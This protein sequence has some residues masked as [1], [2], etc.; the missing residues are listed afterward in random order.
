M[1]IGAGSGQSYFQPRSGCFSGEL[2]K[3]GTFRSAGQLM[4]DVTSASVDW[5]KHQLPEEVTGRMQ[6]TRPWKVRIWTQSLCKNGT[7]AAGRR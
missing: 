5:E 3:P 1:S 6:S 4:N 7:K 2:M